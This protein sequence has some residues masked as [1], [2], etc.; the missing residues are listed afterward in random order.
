MEA[1]DRSPSR[2]KSSQNVRFKRPDGTFRL[3]ML[4]GK[5]KIDSE[6]ADELQ[7]HELSRKRSKNKKDLEFAEQAQNLLWLYR[8]NAIDKLVTNLE[9]SVKPK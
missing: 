5:N 6:M 3:D 1:P 8:K 4:F 7:K 2:S 9:V